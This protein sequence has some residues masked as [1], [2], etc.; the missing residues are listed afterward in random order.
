M[1]QYKV[2]QVALIYSVLIFGIIYALPNFFP[3]KPAIQIAFGDSL[4]ANNTNIISDLSSEL[5]NKNVAFTDIQLEENSAKIIFDEVADQLAARR[6]LSSYS[7]GEFIIALNS[8]PSTP[9]WLS[10]LGGKPINLGL[11]LAGGIHFLLEVDTVRYSTERLS[12]EGAS[13]IDDL[14]DRG[15]NANFE[16]SNENI[17]L[18]FRSFDDLSSARDYLEETNFTT[19]GAKYNVLQNNNDLELQYTDNYLSEIVDYAVEQNL[20]ALRNRVNSSRMSRSSVTVKPSATARA[21]TNIT[22]NELMNRYGRLIG[23]TTNTRN[24]RNTSK[25]PKSVTGRLGKSLSSMF[26]KS[27]KNYKKWQSKRT[28]QK[29]VQVFCQ[30]IIKMSSLGKI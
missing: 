5:E 25:K 1:N 2:W 12:S 29:N 4:K 7:E 23:N 17:N 18:S 16:S 10:S 24:R 28:C 26:R 15:I 6:V 14:Q 22:Y 11:D 19:S 9:S 13:I 27:N 20:V 8:E 21:S 30:K 3:T